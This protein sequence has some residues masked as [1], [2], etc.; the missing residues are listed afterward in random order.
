MYNTYPKNRHVYLVC[1]LQELDV[2]C[3]SAGRGQI[4]IGDQGGTVFVLDKQL[5]ISGFRAYT[6]SVT[7]LHQLRQHNLLFTIGVTYIKHFYLYST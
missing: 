5:N 4:V 1:P 7:H 6:E 2:T 3:S